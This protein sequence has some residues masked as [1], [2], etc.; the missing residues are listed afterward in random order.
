MKK[1]RENT[2]KKYAQKF[3]YKVGPRGGISLIVLV[4]QL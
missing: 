1:Y 3:F 2:N 4:I